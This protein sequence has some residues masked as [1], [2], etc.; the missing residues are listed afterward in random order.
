MQAESGDGEVFGAVGVS[1]PMNRAVAAHTR[2]KVI[3][4]SI[5]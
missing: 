2:W 1:G 4:V 3:T 5:R